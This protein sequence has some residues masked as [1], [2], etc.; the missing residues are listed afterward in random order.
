MPTIS[1]TG[2]RGGVG[3]SVFAWAIAREI[4]ANLLLDYSNT[5][6]LHW[7]VGH[8]ELDLSWPATIVSPLENLDATKL[9]QNANRVEGIQI[10]SGGTPIAIEVFDPKQIVVVDGN[11]K[12]DFYINLRTNLLQDIASFRDINQIVVLR[13]V[14]GGTPVSLIPFKIDYTYKSEGSVERSIRNGIGL[15]PKSKIQKI[16]RQISADILRDS[17]QNH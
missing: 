14:G 12:A 11:L 10:F 17:S 16:A 6:C 5:Q 7:V 15:H 4:S 9:I 1:V 2:S 3:T 8:P 13:K